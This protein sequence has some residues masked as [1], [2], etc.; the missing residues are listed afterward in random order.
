VSQRPLLVVLRPLG[1]GDFLTGVPA[2][3]AIARA[4]P[5]HR[6]VLAAPDVFAPLLDLTGAFDAVCPTRPLEPLDP[7]LHDADIAV[8]LHGRGPASHTILLAARARRLIAFR[9][10]AIEQSADGAPWRD[11]EHEVVRWCRML[12]HVGIPADPRDLDLRLPE[13]RRPQP[14]V[15]IIHA[16]A[17]SE[18]RRWPVERWAAVARQEAA[19]GRIVMLTGSNAER[20][21]AADIAERAG[22]PPDRMVAGR[23]NLRQLAGLVA[24]AGRVI[25][26]DTGVAHLAT[27]LRVPSVVLF[28]PIAPSLWGPPADR[29]IHRALWAGRRGDP[30]GATIDPGLLEIT[31]TD[32]VAAIRELD[33]AQRAVSSSG[34]PASAVAAAV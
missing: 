2:Y 7:L 21:R 28:G 34:S 16:A 14:N 33:T 4:F 19:D 30:H 29:P 18:S 26:G 17:A 23:T 24:T 20:E 13:R 25:S 12:A 27:A 8:D 11:D 5:H 6:R 3:R 15:T 9:N 32:V 22:F 1:L 10:L 31:V